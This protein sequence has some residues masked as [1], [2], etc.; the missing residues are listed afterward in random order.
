VSRIFSRFQQMR[1]IAAEGKEVHILAPL[2]LS[3]LAGWH[4]D[5]S[6]I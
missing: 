2:E 1:L 5:D 6:P 3:T 4:L